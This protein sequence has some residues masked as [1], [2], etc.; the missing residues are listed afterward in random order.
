MLGLAKIIE[1]MEVGH[2]V[3]HAQWDWMRDPNIQSNTWEW[4]SVCPSDQWKHSHNVIHHTWTN[5]LGKDPDVGYGILRVTPQQ[6]W[7][8]RYLAQPITNFLLMLLFEWGVAAHD[9]EADKLISGEKSLSS[10]RPMLRRI[11]WK[12]SRQLLKDY[13]LLA[14]TGRTRH[15]AVRL[16]FRARR[17][18][19]DACSCVHFGGARQ[20]PRE[21]HP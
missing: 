16:R 2:N 12:A 17:R 4:D 5:V 19:D 7:E 9:L 20:C 1:N 21:S 13:V 6:P 10:V 3:M 14:G 11:A 8:P 18:A 15:A